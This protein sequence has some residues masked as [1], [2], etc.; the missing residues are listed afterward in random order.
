MQRIGVIT[1]G[2]GAPGMNAAIRSLIRT[3][4]FHGLEGQ[5]RAL[6]ARSMGEI[7][8]QGGT[9]LRTAG[10]SQGIPKGGKYVKGD[11]DRWA[12]NDGR[13]R[14]IQGCE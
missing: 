5:V 7:M 11:R 3:S 8:N 6:G 9:M 1:A 4:T 10:V 2:E 14:R 12:N 13:R